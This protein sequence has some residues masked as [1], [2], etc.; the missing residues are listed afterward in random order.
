[1]NR[2]HPDTVDFYDREAVKLICEKYGLVP[3]E[4]LRRFVT[5]ETHRL[6]EDADY[7]LQEFGTPAVF[8]MWE[9]EQVTG[10]PRSSIYVRE[11]KD[12]E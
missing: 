7:G 9:A 3:M 11:L 10:S 2:Q 1:M 8:D 5:S 4:A 6:L 12:G